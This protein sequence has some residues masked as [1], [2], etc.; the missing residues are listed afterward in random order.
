LAEQEAAAAAVAAAW[1][2]IPYD[3]ENNLASFRISSY[4]VCISMTWI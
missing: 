4:K 2:V 3:I 1:V